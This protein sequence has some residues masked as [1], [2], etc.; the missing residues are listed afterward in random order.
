MSPGQAQILR[1]GRLRYHGEA[2]RDGA[3]EVAA[4]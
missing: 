3:P 2:V 1:C 4:A